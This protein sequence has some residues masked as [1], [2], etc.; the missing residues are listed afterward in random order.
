MYKSSLVLT[1]AWES[2]RLDLWGQGTM[3]SYLGQLCGQGK[4][5]LIF[6]EFANLVSI[7][8]QSAIVNPQR[9]LHK[10]RLLLWRQNDW[11][12]KAGIVSWE[13]VGN[14]GRQ[15]PPAKFS[16]PSFLN[17]SPQNSPAQ[18]PFKQTLHKIRSQPGLQN[19]QFNIYFL[20]RYIFPCKISNL[21]F[22]PF[23]DISFHAKFPI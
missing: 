16:F 9:H 12:Q 18:R 17:S 6:Q 3:I 11:L 8:R 19:F 10:T 5:T 15:G 2:V 22:I 14:I 23:K 21:I 13:T 4:P 7:Y 20:L 1:I